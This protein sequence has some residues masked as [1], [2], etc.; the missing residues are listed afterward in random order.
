VSVP[1][2]P[3]YDCAVYDEFAVAVPLAELPDG[4]AVRELRF[5]LEVWCPRDK[6]DVLDTPAWATYAP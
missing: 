4:Y 5:T 3:P 6:K 1:F 2:R